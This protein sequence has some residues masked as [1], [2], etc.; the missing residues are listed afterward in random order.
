MQY[1][2]GEYTY[3]SK[4]VHY[5]RANIYKKAPFQYKVQKKLNVS[6]IFRA[7][8]EDR[9]PYN[10][11]KVNASR[12]KFVTSFHFSKIFALTINIKPIVVCCR[13]SISNLEHISGNHQLAGFCIM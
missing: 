11:I 10:P 13:S 1:E 7:G 12:R 5:I 8:E 2:H 3:I 9:K 6:L 4:K